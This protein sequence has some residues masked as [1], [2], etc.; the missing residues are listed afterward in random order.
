M[1]HAIK[2]R[3]NVKAFVAVAGYYRD[4]EAIRRS[5][6][7]DFRSKVEQGRKAR[8]GFENSGIAETIPAVALDRDA[9]MKLQSTYDYYAH[10]AAHP[11]YINEFA[12]MSREHF[13]PFDVQSAASCITH[14]FLMLH[15]PNALNPSWAETFFDAVPSGKARA[16]IQSNNQTEIYD[17]PTI[18][19]K[20][21]MFAAQFLRKHLEPDH[22]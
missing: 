5:D 14:P 3:P 18:V 10:R 21:T 4:V 11:N 19:G 8:K 15:G 22:R 9:A 17:D 12:V 20:A 7:D 6:P 16:T 1:A 2:E 13:L